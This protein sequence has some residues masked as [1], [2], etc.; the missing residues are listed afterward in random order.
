MLKARALTY[1]VGGRRLLNAVS[2]DFAPGTVSMVVGANG[3]GKTTLMRALCRSIAPQQG[4]VWYG[5]RALADW[6]DGELARVRGV[7]S[8]NLELPFPLRVRDV[9][10]MGRNP[11]YTGM[12]TSHDEAVC[13][14]AM[15][16]FEVLPWADR[17]YLTLSGGERQRVHFARVMAQIWES[18]PDASR[19]LLLDEPLTYLDI[20]HQFD[21]LRQL[22]FFAS[23]GDLVVVAVVHDLNLAARHADQ[24]VLMAEGQVLQAGPPRE[25]LTPDH[26]EAGFG[27]RPIVYESNGG[28]HVL[29]E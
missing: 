8:Q 15:Q 9:V 3:A 20:R 18:R 23:T 22:R 17:D 24:V 21:F 29:F 1:T 2:V 16:H 7:L 26:V 10:M 19:Y 4:D 27:V 6:R 28:M 13:R 25:V 14:Q 11:H 12:P 5:A